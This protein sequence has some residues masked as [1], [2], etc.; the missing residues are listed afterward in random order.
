M[1]K[2]IYVGMAAAIPLRLITAVI[3]LVLV[4]VALKANAQTET[5][6][7]MFTG[8]PTDGV[9]PYAGLVQGNDGNFYETTQDGRTNSCDYGTV[10]R[11]SPSSSYTNLHIFV[12]YGTQR[13]NVRDPMRT[14]A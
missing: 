14:H 11:I 2:P 8:Y 12:G 10:F 9:D 1:N 13:S 6:L 3:L 5:I 7:H 4:G